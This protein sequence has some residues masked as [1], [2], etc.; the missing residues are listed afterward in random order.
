MF[1]IVELRSLADMCIIASKAFD[2]LRVF[3]VNIPD[4]ED[5]RVK[6]LKIKCLRLAKE[7]ELAEA[8]KAPE[9]K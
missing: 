2:S 8:P 3:G 1:S 6:S 9:G 7:Q 4:D 5:I